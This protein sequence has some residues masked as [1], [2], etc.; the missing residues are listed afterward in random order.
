MGFDPN[1]GLNFLCYG[2][3]GSGKTTLWSSFPKPILCIICSGGQKP[4]ELRSINTPEMRKVVSTVTLQRPSEMDEVTKAL[5]LGVLKHGSGH[6]YAT[7]VLDH[8]SGFQDLKLMAYKGLSAIPQ[9]KSFGIATKQDWGEITAQIKEHLV[10]LLSLRCNVVVIGQE[11]VFLPGRGDDDDTKNLK[12]AMEEAGVLKPKV[13]AALTPGLVGWLNPTCD[14]IVQTFIR[15]R[16]IE[17]ESVT[18]VGGKEV[19]SVMRTRV[20]GVEF[21]A[22][23]GKHEIFMTKFRVPD[24]K[25]PEVLVLGD[26]VNGVRKKPS[27]YD[28]IIKLINGA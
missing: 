6:P 25:L 27:G 1:D 14:Y 13:G 7:V 4:G 12:L 20:P 5:D 8:V 3:S 24:A 22:R 10:K 19:K 26:S 21:C 28:Q 16:Y 15:D 17:E 9:Q 18:K 2:D 23:T 11:R